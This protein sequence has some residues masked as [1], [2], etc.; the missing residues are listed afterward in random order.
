M[1]NLIYNCDKDIFVYIGYELKLT[2]T[3]HKVLAAIYKSKRI[4]VEEIIS[5]CGLHARGRGNVS[6]HVHSI[7]K[8]AY[9][10]GG[11]KLVVFEGGMYGLNEYM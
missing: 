8:K 10:I 3:E 9:D 7:N 6:V 11:R 1:E 4:G 2:P 5:E